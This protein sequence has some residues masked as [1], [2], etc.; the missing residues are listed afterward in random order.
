MKP[1]VE[2]KNEGL[3]QKP[4]FFCLAMPLGERQLVFAAM[5]EGAKREA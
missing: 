5:G 2:T 1:A 4:S 3:K